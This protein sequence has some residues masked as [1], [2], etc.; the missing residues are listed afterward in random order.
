MFSRLK[1]I[2]NRIRSSVAAFLIALIGKP[3]QSSEY[4]R[5]ES[6]LEYKYRT[7]V[8][9]PIGRQ[10]LS[11]IDWTLRVIDSNKHKYQDAYYALITKGLYVPWEVIAVL[12]V[13][14]S[15]GNLRNQILNGE[16]YN[17]VTTKV[18]SGHGPWSSWVD[19]TV[20]AFKQRSLPKDWTIDETLDFLERWNG[21]G[22]RRMGRNSP[23][24]W[25]YSSYQQKGKFVRDGVFDSEFISLQVGAAVL[26][27]GLGY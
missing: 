11:H 16:A 19:S 4:E 8:H 23:Y 9:E 13:M 18:P 1:S 25:A 26:L 7:M 21:L 2:L 10:K 27:K 24:L 20:Y 3:A 15:G 22:Y 17:R 6:Q 5:T 14:E 12:H